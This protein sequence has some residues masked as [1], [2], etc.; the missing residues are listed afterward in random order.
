MTLKSRL[1]LAFFVLFALSVQDVKAN[2]RELPTVSLLTCSPGEELYSK[3]GH[4]ALRLYYPDSKRDLVFNFGIFDFNTPNFYVKF[5]RGKLKYMLGIQYMDEFM[6]QYRWENKG[7]TEQQLNLTDQQIEEVEKRL[8]FLYRPA[9]R[10]YLY[11][12]LYKN[13]TSEVRDIIFS[14]ADVD[15]DLYK[16]KSGV[17]NR[18]LINS[19]V[20]G[21]AKFGINMILGSTLDREVDIFQTMFLPNNLMEVVSAAE[22]GNQSLLSH[23]RELLKASPV[24]KQKAGRVISF[25]YSPV[26]IFSLVLLVM[27]LFCFRRSYFLIFHNLYISIAGA[28]GLLLWVIILFTEHVELYSNYNLLLF[29]PL[30]ILVS[31]ASAARLKKTERVLSAISL[32]SLSILQIVWA[33]NIQYAEPAFYIIALSLALS[34]AARII[35]NRTVLLS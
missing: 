8:E 2:R 23:Q 20:D 9:N 26:A 7:V 29:N 31:I 5:I 14:I 27:A 28:T 19:Y 15:R 12:F 22:N 18:E 35:K 17:T 13:C 21:W 3:F 6:A 16:T 10:Y 34:F 4:T 33:Q 1:I 24:F 32:L 30:F 11:S 25:L